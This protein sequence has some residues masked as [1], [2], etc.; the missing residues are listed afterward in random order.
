MLIKM[1]TT[2]YGP[3][4]DENFQKGQ[5]RDVSP[6]EADYWIK[7]GVAE[8]L[9]PFPTPKLSGKPEKAT[10]GPKEVAVAPAAATSSWG[11]GE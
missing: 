7:Q 10:T 11:K 8:A 1:K 5:K 2:S 6:E 9:E 4:P 3:N